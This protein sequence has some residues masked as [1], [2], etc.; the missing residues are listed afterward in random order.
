MRQIS[1]QLF[2]SVY[3]K[4]YFN[5]KFSPILL[6]I[7]SSKTSNSCIES[8]LKFEINVKINKD[9]K[10][11]VFESKDVSLIELNDQCFRIVYIL[12]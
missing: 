2:V 6:S 7:Y 1:N 8:N 9:F 11:L 3:N 12:R 4:V 5:C 10:Q